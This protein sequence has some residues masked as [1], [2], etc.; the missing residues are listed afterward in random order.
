MQ[1]TIYLLSLASSFL[2]LFFAGL[3]KNYKEKYYGLLAGFFILVML[4]V[5]GLSS[6]LKYELGT[7]TIYTYSNASGT[8]LEQTVLTTDYG[9]VPSTM[10][11]IL[12]ILFI[13][14]GVGGL[15]TTW[16][17]DSELKYYE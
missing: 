4:G 16:F 2:F 13:L 14:I 17:Y 9:V 10:E 1:I 7:T 12:N 11:Y 8:P 5:V 3:N 6:P 15:Y